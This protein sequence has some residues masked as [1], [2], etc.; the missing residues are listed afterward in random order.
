MLLFYLPVLIVIFANT[1]Y[2]ISSKSIPEE[3]NAYAGVTIT[4]TILAFFNFSLFHILNPDGSMFVEISRL[5]WAVILFALASVGLECG[6]I[7]LYRAGWNISI[8]GVVCNI[9]LAVCMIIVGI[10]V[11][12]ETITPRQFTGIIFC[13]GGLLTINKME[14]KKVIGEESSSEAT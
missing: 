14:L 5:N 6:Y 10:S 4:Y 2:D 8:G 7:Y 9:L 1:T 11:F 3:L 12:H 13:V